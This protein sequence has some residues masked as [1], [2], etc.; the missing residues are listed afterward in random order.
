MIERALAKS[1]PLRLPVSF[2]QQDMREF[3]LPREVHLVTSFFDSLNHVLSLVDLAEVFR[4]VHAALHP[5]G[6]FVFDMNNELCFTLL[7]TKSE[8]ISHDDFVLEL[9]NSY[10][11]GT[12]LAECRVTLT[13]RV[14]GAELVPQMEVV[15]E[16]WYP[17]PTVREALLNAGFTVRASEDF[18]FTLNPDVGKIK[19]WW[20][21]EKEPLP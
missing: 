4:R 7:W 14:G 10:D 11:R 21:A 8:L 13:G 18:N 16:K 6:W 1:A 15:R 2:L 20:V 3:R 12:G 19:T 5:G 9:D 17:A